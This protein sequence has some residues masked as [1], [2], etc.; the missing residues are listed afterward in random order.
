MNATN[1]IIN[2]L[3]AMGANPETMTDSNGETLIKVNAPKIKEEDVR[4]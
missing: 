4:Q 3:R 1:Q 2:V